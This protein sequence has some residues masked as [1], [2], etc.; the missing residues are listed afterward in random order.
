MGIHASHC[1]LGVENDYCVGHNLF[2]LFVHITHFFDY[3]VVL[4][5]RYNGQ[6]LEMDTV[7]VTQGK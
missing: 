7:I 1:I 3:K 5:G 2:D 6:G 4:L